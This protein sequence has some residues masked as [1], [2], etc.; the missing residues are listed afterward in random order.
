MK[1][2]IRDLKARAPQVVREVR[3]TG[4]TIDVTYH[5]EV[6]AHITPAQAA[7]A[8]HTFGEA[9]KEFDAVAQ[10]IGKRAKRRP[11]ARGDWRRTL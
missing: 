7:K 1:I 3:E 5:G 6:V 10:A 9:W 4:V 11:A 8:T 2:G